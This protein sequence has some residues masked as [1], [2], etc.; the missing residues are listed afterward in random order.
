VNKETVDLIRDLAAKLGTTAEH[1]WGVLLRQA[2]ISGATDLMQYALLAVA[3]ALWWKWVKATK[4]RGQYRD[5]AAWIPVGT[6]GVAL[7]VMVG[8]AFFSFPTTVAAF[9]NPE[10]WALKQVMP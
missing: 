9:F 5:E 10:Y 8:V 4:K 1:L 3:V 6:V 2:P 7:A